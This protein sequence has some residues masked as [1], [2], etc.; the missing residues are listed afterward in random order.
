LDEWEGDTKYSAVTSKTATSNWQSVGGP[1][2]Y[3]RGSRKGG[4]F[5]GN[6]IRGHG[7]TEVFKTNTFSPFPECGNF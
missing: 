1:R 4:G 5:V 3:P 6:E 2:S 7:T